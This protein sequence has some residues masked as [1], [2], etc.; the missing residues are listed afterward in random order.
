MNISV[1]K[2]GIL[3]DEAREARNAYGKH[4]GYHR[5]EI[6]RITKK[7][8]WEKERAGEEPKVPDVVKNQP[9]DWQWRE[10]FLV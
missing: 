1:E 7:N 6:E 10:L 3:V 9:N 5:I 2:L 8:I 4:I